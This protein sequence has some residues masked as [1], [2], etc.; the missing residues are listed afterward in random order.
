[1]AAAGKSPVLAAKIRRRAKSRPVQ[2]AP[3]PLCPNSITIL[4]QNGRQGNQHE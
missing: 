3:Y 1:M 4:G 2:N